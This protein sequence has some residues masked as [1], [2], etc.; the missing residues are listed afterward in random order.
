MKL[1]ADTIQN[2]GYFHNGLPKIDDVENGLPLISV[3][4]NNAAAEPVTIGHIEWEADLLI[5][6]YIPFHQGEEVLDE[7]SEQI[8]KTMLS[9]SFQHF[10]IR[11]NFQQSY[12][13]EY[14]TENNVWVSAAISYRINYQFTELYHFI[15]NQQTKDLDNV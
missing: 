1:L 8:N 14:D 3:Y 10:S 4:L 9:N 5:L 12:D 6:T 13:Y 11:H 15:H 7:I 2:V